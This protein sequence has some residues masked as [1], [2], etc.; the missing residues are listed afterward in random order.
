M[1]EY[2]HTE[3]RIG[4]HKVEDAIPKYL[5]NAQVLLLLDG[6]DE[7]RAIPRA[8]ISDEI[9]TIGRRLNRAK[10]ILSCRSGD[11]TKQMDGFSVVEI[12]PL[13]TDQIIRIKEK[14][15]GKDDTLFMQH[16]KNLPYYDVSDRPLL[17]TQLLFLYKRYGYFP[18]QPSQI[19]TKLI[20]LLLEEWDAER[21]IKRLS[22]YAGFDPK[23]KS[24]FLSA[25][26][27]HL[28][29]AAEITRFKEDDLVKAYLK[30]CG[31]FRLPKE[32]ARQ[33]SQEIQ[34]HTGIILLGPSDTYEFCHL[35]LQEYLC[36]EYIV[37]TPVEMQSIKYL[38]KYSAPLAVAVSLSSNPSQWFSSLILS[39]GNTKYFD[40]ISMA[41]FISRIVVER[42][43]FELSEPLGF[44]ML[45]LFKHHNQYTP[46]FAYLNDMLKI[47]VV[48]GSIA[49]ALRWYIPKHTYTPKS[50]LVQVELNK[51]LEKTYNFNLP[52]E[53]AF[54]R[55]ILTKLKEAKGSHLYSR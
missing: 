10:I 40:T 12:C 36:A 4:D 55:A 7:L 3:M 20:N 9:I 39:Y 32:E 25:L 31:R 21:G 14:W 26:A 15:L 41:S 52:D 23:K 27:Y 22:Q 6:L 29:Y 54:P 34:T 18:E 16:L 53:G 5:N 28:T 48:L 1:A 24:E 45:S 8:N 38:A 2:K 42:P 46:A 49:S 17:L 50:T 19:Y 47:D 51:K 13:N 11:Y 35:S 44:A 43:G 37:R 30:L 33:V